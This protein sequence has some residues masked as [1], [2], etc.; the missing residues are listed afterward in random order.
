MNTLYLDL[1]SGISG[2]MFVGALLDL[3]ADFG[4]LEAALRSLGVRGF[5]VHAGKRQNGGISGTKFDV[6]LDPGDG[7]HQPHH[8]PHEPGHSHAHDHTDHVAGG[9]HHH[10]EE[11]NFRDIRELIAASRLSDWVKERATAVFV[12]LAE[13]E[14]KVHGLPADEVHFHEVGA[15]DSIVDIVGACVGLELLGK[16]R[17]LASAVTEGTGFVD[18]AHGRLPVPVPATVELLAQRGVPYSQCEEPGELVTPT[19]AALL[20][21][22]A[23]AFGPAEDLRPL[24]VGYGLGTHENRTRPNVLRAILGE[25]S[26]ANP[27]DWERDSVAVLETNL[28]DVSGEVLG[29]FLE[30]ALAAGALDVFH[31]SIQMKKHRPGVL[32]TLLC[33]VERADEFARLILTETTAFG[34]RQTVAERRKLRRRS[35][36][37]ATIFGLVTVKEGHLDGRCVQWAPEY[38]SCRELAEKA[39]VPVRQVFAAAVEANRSAE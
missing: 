25:A 28:D 27:S 36:K 9:H 20:V 33:T 23:G 19:G 10:A 37:V 7:G 32:L 8:H 22:L 38:E 1:S 29:D 4:Q 12:R 18:C 13:A 14:G 16:P 34:V 6:H 30:R 2:D 3:G 24:K 39:G 26:G 5:H 17:V 31:T 35:A 21:E 15:V 11:R